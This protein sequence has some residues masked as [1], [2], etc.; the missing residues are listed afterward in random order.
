LVKRALLRFDYTNSSALLKQ[1][2]EL[3]VSLN[4]TPLVQLKLDPLAPNG[5][6]EVE[7]PDTLLIQGY[8]IVNFRAIQH[9]NL[10]C[11]SA[12][13]PELWTR[14]K[15]D[16]AMLTIEYEIETAPLKLSAL[17]E[18]IFDAKFIPEAHLHLITENFTENTLTPAAIV[19][20]GAALRF[21][22][23]KTLFTL[24]N[25]ITENM[26]NLLVGEKA[27]VEG[28]LKKQGVDITVDGPTLKLVHLPSKNERGEAAL[29]TRHI[30]LVVAGR[31]TDEIRL[32]AETMSNLSIPFPDTDE[33]KMSEFELPEI[34][35]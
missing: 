18:Q 34:N 8:N 29:D 20:S 3:V 35:L 7:L 14:L 2:S 15:L 6:A 16:E 23:R 17:P 13:A 5:Y 9:Y 11:E 22:Y 30:L 24:S 19:A 26:D 21:D 4:D 27:Y 12:C 25:Q 10:G 31:N 1:N 33:V 32:A 28:F